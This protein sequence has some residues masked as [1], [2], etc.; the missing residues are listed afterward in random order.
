MD[1]V[2][3]E[4]AARVPGLAVLVV[5]VW[6][7]VRYVSKRDEQIEL[8]F[9]RRDDMFINAHKEMIVSMEKI[10]ESCEKTGLATLHSLDRNTEIMS[11]LS[12]DLK[13]R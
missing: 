2:L 9:S 3:I 7:F 6:I 10:E 5:V 13:K 12:D 1:S 8:A 11:R 4:A